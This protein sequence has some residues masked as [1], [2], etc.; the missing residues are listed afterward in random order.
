[1]DI[2]SIIL[3]GSLIITT[4]GALID[5]ILILVPS[6]LIQPFIR[7]LPFSSSFSAI[8]PQQVPEDLSN[9]KDFNISNVDYLEANS[10]NSDILFILIYS[11][12]LAGEYISGPIVPYMLEQYR[13][14]TYLLIPP[15]GLHYFM[16]MIGSIMWASI[17][18]WETLFKF[19][20]LLIASGKMM[21]LLDFSIM[22]M[23]CGEFLSFF[24]YF[25]FIILSEV[26]LLNVMK[27]TN[28]S[29][30]WK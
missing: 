6:S 3:F 24:G 15:Y 22:M 16:A 20:P 5:V 12:T 29:S 11:L 8:C 26:F 21:M 14:R 7:F 1:M 19:S 4:L 23:F 28:R 25:S 2:F 10:T 9:K 13:M 18:D 30:T 17:F 27:H